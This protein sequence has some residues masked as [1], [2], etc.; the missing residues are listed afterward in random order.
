[1][2]EAGAFWT[3][4]SWVS[5]GLKGENGMILGLKLNKYPSA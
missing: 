2:E 3:P 1:M 4:F 5:K